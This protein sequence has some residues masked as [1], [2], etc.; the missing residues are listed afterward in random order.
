MLGRK[1]M[2]T[3][4]EEIQ[5]LSKFT[6]EPINLDEV[7]FIVIKKAKKY[8]YIILITTL[9]VSIKSSHLVKNSYGKVKAKVRN[10]INKHLSHK[11]R[12]HKEKEVSSFLK[13]VSDYKRKIR[14]IKHRIKEEEGIE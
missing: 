8:G 5:H 14:Q 11:E 13:M 10:K 6:I 3:N 4:F 2:F 7:K 1:L 9:R 12:I